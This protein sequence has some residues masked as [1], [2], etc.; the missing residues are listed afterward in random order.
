MADEDPEPS[1]WRAVI[2]LGLIALLIVGVLLV[3]NEL[4]Q[5]TALQDC[6]VSGR[7]NCAPIPSGR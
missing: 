7:T 2:G 3:I 5:A 4:R 1:Q 6:V